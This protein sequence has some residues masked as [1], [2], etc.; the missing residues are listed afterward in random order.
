MT[1]DS[2]PS[3]ARPP[4]GPRR[5]PSRLAGRHRHG[6]GLVGGGGG[7]VGGGG[8][9]GRVGLGVALALGGLVV[10]RAGA[11]LGRD[12]TCPATPVV[13]PAMTAAHPLAAV[14]VGAGPVYPGL[15]RAGPGGGPPPP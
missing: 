7:G 15:V 10:A 1:A 14:A 11:G 4:R 8:G 5:C 12:G 6:G 9:G 13:G 3:R 2:R